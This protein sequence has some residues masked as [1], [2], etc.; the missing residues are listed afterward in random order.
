MIRVVL[1]GCNGKMGHTVRSIIDEN[2]NMTVAAGID[3]S[4]GDAKFPVFTD[5]ALCD[6]EADVIIDFSA[7]A[8]LD[9]IMKLALAKGIPAVLCATGYSKEQ[10]DMI[11]EASKKVAILRSANMSLGINIL[12]KL[13]EEASWLR[14]ATT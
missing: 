12:A 2:D 8:A 9:G 10:L 11:A 3:I 1:G 4:E 7:P 13:I 14:E 5:A 6:V